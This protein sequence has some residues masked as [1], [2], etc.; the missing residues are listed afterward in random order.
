MPSKTL[1][2]RAFMKK[3]ATDPAFAEARDIPQKVAREFRT[4]DLK[5]MRRK[6]QI[7]HIDARS[8][9]QS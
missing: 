6:H 9:A 8:H 5:R 7:H 4:S 3:A 1:K 2:Q